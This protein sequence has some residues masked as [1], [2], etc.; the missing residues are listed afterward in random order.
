MLHFISSFVFYGRSTRFFITRG[1]A[2]PLATPT[3]DIHPRF[4]T[5]T[6][7]CQRLG[8]GKLFFGGMFVSSS[9]FF[10]E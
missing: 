2:P 4:V 10:G 3:G 1:L 8:G 7:E 9:P 6:R 5:L